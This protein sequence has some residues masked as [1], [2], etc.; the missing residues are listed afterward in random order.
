VACWVASRGPSGDRGGPAVV[1]EPIQRLFEP[2][3]AQSGW[4]LL[5]HCRDQLE[6][7]LSRLLKVPRSDQ[8][9]EAGSISCGARLASAATPPTAPSNI[10]A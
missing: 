9:V 6:L 8:V 3:D 5:R 1:A 10:A 7:Q 2:R 4:W